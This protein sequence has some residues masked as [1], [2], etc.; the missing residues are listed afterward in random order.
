MAGITGNRY[1]IIRQI[2]AGGMGAV[3][4]VYDRLRQQSVALKQVLLPDDDQRLAITREFR[5][6]STLR[7]PNIVSVL[8]YGVHDGQPYFTLEY[9][10]DAQPL[11]PGAGHD[12]ALFLPV[13]QA[14]GYLHR[15]G[16]LHRDLK[17]ANVL[18]TP[19]GQVKVLDFGLAQDTRSALNDETAL[20]GTLKYMAPELFHGEPASAGSDLWSVGV[21]LCE[22]LAGHLPYTATEATSLIMALLTQPPNLAGVP[23]AL[24]PVLERLLARDPDERYPGAMTALRDLCAAAG[25]DLPAESREQRESFLQSAAFVGRE[26]EYQRLADALKTAAAGTAQFWLLG[27]E[28]GAGKSRLLDELRTRALVDGFVVLNG[29]A[30]EGGGLPF[31]LWRDLAR[32]LIFGPPM[33]DLTASV[34]KE[35]VPDIGRLLQR[36][37]ADAP[38]LEPRASLDRLI[39]A[40]L[41]RLALLNAPVL[42]ILEDL[43]WDINSLR[44]IR[45]IQRRLAGLKD[46]RLMVVGSYRSEEKPDLPQ[47]LPEFSVLSIDRLTQAAIA[48]LSAS[49]L[50]PE[51]A[52][53]R[54][55]SRLA[56]ET[57][58]N[59]LF[60]VEV[61][62][63]LAEEAGRLDDIT[64]DS[65]PQRILAGGMVAVLRRRLARVPADALPTLRLA[66]VIGRIIDRAILQAAGVTD[67][68]AWLQA[69][70]EAAVLEVQ[71]D[72]W[73]FSH[74]RLREVL[75]LD[76]P[77]V[78]PLHERAALAIEAAHPHNPAYA[79]A[80]AQHWRMAGQPQREMPCLLQH[81]AAL[82]EQRDE[83]EQADTF[84]QRGLALNMPQHLAE[85]RLWQGAVAQARSDYPAALQAFTEGL[86]ANP[87]PH[88]EATLLNRAATVC[89][90]VSRY[91]EATDY[92][93][94]AHATATTLGDARNL[95]RS[96]ATR[97]NILLD[98]SDHDLA[99]GYFEDTL[100][101]ARGAEDWRGVC[102]ALI[103]LGNTAYQTSRREPARA[104]YLQ[105]ITMARQIGERQTLAVALNNLGTLATWDNDLDTAE[106]YY[107]ESLR[108]RRELGQPAAI[109][110]SLQS[111]GS[112]AVQ[113][114]DY[115]TASALKEEALSIQQQIGDRWG[116]AVTMLSLAGQYRAQGA[117]DTA[118]SYHQ[119]SLAIVLELGA[120]DVALYNYGGLVIVQHHLNNPAAARQALVDIVRLAERLDVAHGQ[121]MAIFCAAR[122]F[123][124]EARA[125]AWIGLL[126]ASDDA[127]M[128]RQTD[129]YP[130]LRTDSAAALGAAAFA[131]G[132]ADGAALSLRGVVAA[133]AK[134]LRPPA[135]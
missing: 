47:E 35:I 86:A 4:L 32:R 59:A 121:A 54:L 103:G 9:L 133:L 94:R 85:L 56:Q 135:A 112:L 127:T 34:L 131:A 41:E 74:D 79:G 52:T 95:W 98:Q 13:L 72:E 21:M 64:D 111:L 27:G 42:V 49:M 50:G 69:C 78:G 6:L 114:A 60:M 1:E 129:D 87:A 36:D 118:L 22:M 113:R 128:I 57:E 84:I 24:V 99:Q 17:P 93:R 43:H 132:L 65:L 110:Y 90:S 91:D 31:Q 70:A 5:T 80:L 123:Y 7:H 53:P 39:A 77:D 23:A 38:P 117:Y 55:V 14:I 58:G 122:L 26:T 75:L 102:Q 8:D 25:I 29:Q 101:I 104:Y 82:I 37:V 2:G 66:A 45:L 119:Q 20:S 105:A 10:P 40:L 100:R 44:L 108:L 19:A 30:V 92:A 46:L 61:I 67:M 11:Q 97:G 18:V 28:A 33:P 51:Q 134:E 68:E 73:R 76:L 89:F 126:D 107:Q 115:A 96:L 125:A 3:W 71:Q 81:V 63:A 16:I 130:T 48:A 120:E 116:A 124:H 15:R 12:L 109:A 83:Y 106:S 62:R 88:T